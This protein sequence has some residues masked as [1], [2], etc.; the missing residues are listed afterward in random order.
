MAMMTVVM[1]KMDNMPTTTTMMIPIPTPMIW[2][3]EMHRPSRRHPRKKMVSM[4]TCQLSLSS[5]SLV[6]VW[7]YSFA[8]LLVYFIILIVLTREEKSRIERVTCDI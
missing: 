7:F 4:I 5:F 1:M 2:M 6:L 3:V 8:G